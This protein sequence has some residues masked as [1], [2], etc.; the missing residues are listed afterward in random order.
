MEY[1]PALIFSALLA[2]FL[3]WFPDVSAWWSTLPAGR[4]TTVNAFGVAAIAIVMMLLSCQRGGECP[5]D[6]W[7]AVGEFLLTALLSL[8]ANQATY[9]AT[10]RENF[11]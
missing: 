10:K 6:V 7:A 4:K 5:A 3:E 2:L 1:T 8:A 9:Q 11:A